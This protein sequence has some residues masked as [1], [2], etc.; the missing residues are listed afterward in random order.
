M[1]PAHGPRILFL[2]RAP[3]AH[4]LG[5]S[6]TY[7]INLIALL[8]ELGAEVTV[9]S[10]LAGSRSA[11]PWFVLRTSFPPSVRLKV[12]GY[13]RVG[14]TYLRVWSPRAWARTIRRAAARL[15]MLKPLE[16]LIEASFRDAT[17]EFAWDLTP[18]TEREH[19]LVVRELRA[20]Q[21]ATLLANYAIWGPVLADAA[22]RATVPGLKRVILMHDLL[23]ARVRS[24]E[25]QGRVLDCPRIEEAT[26]LGWLDSADTLLAAQAREAEAI[27]A[28][29]SAQVLVL[30][31]TMSAHEAAAAPDAMRCLFVGSRI[32]PNEA[33]LTWLLDAVW[34]AVR[35]ACP[36]ATL[37]VVGTVADSLGGRSVP[38]VL[39]VG[40]VPSIDDEYAKAAVCVVPLRIGSGIKIKLLEALS[41][42]KAIVSTSIGV[43]G[44]EELAAGA[45]A[46]ADDAAGFAQAMVRLLRDPDAR[47]AIEAKAY[48]LAR[49]QFDPRRQLDP[50]FLDA[51]L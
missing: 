36:Q 42:G 18:P 30:P 19:T 3:V 38:G 50:R 44:L 43:E 12:P 15:P 11:R 26:E 28:K 2:T 13:L 47:R 20:L 34:P 32:A 1:K 24:F 31:V 45:V 22:V 51:L 21:P 7:A 9:L 33:A 17:C 48:A 40:R 35:A 49:T 46:V 29:V 23:S 27:A 37:A 41:F 5:G 6:T 8:V 10:T 14:R 16:R 39:A 4:E 25:S